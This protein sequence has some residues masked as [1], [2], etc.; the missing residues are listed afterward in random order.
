M[1]NRLLITGN[2]QGYPDLDVTD[3][4]FYPSQNYPDNGGKFVSI[5]ETENGLELNGQY[6]FRGD[7]S[8]PIER[9]TYLKGNNL[10]TAGTDAFYGQQFYDYDHSALVTL[11]N[12]PH[13]NDDSFSW[14]YDGIISYTVDLEEFPDNNP[15]IINSNGGTKYA[16]SGELTNI[17]LDV[18]D[19]DGDAL[20]YTLVDPPSNGSVVFT[21]TQGGGVVTYTSTAGFSG[22]ETFSYKASDGINESEVAQMSIEVIEKEASLNWS[23][24]YSSANLKRTINDDQKNTYTAGSFYDFSNFKDNTTLNAIYPRG[25]DG[26]IAKYNA[27]G[28][29]QWTNTFGGASRDTALD[30]KLDNEGNIIVAGQIVKTATFSDGEELGDPNAEANKY[31]TVVLKLDGNTGEIIWKNYTDTQPEP[32]RIHCLQSEVIIKLFV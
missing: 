12:I 20:T 15:P 30:I 29:L 22:I 16:F 31:Y 3:D 5:Y 11:A 1:E 19:Q 25:Y 32:I 9:Q 24:F 6:F 21:E 18:S 2:M 17:Q 28:E 8:S 26:Y 23:R 13:R 7:Q 14:K 27:D 4:Q 10:I